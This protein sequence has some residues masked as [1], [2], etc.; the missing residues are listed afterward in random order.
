MSL[1]KASPIYLFT[2][3]ACSGNP[4]PGAWAYSL[5]AKGQV[6]EGVDFCEA[7]TNNRMELTAILKGLQKISQNNL[8]GDIYLLSDSKYSLDGLS[9]WRFGWKKR[10]WKKADG[11]EVLNRDIWESLDQV[12]S[13]LKNINY[14]HVRAHQGISMNERVDS[15]AYGI[16]QKS[17]V[18]LYQGELENY[19]HFKLAEVVSLLDVKTKSTTGLKKKKTSSSKSQYYI[20]LV[21][22]ELLRHKTWKECSDRVTGV[23]GAKFKKVSSTQEEQDFLNRF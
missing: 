19:S 11:S 22:G 9:K 7:T 3:G 21:Q 15:L 13:S 1:N 14:Q 10:A 12:A 23:S 5:I 6:I 16:S 4:G 20:S 2:D 17:E 18:S 8:V